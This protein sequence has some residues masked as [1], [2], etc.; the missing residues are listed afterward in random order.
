MTVIER[1]ESLLNERG[2]KKK[3]VY[4]ILGVSPSTYTTWV[5]TNTASIP[6]EYVPKIANLFGLTC[7]ELLTGETKIISDENTSRLIEI[8][9]SLSWD[10][11]Q[12]VIA[13][14]VEEKRYESENLPPR[15]RA[16]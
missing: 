9:N 3:A 2:M 4:E 6:S 5:A 12:M 7:D 13:K 1:I 10:G 11:Q 8:Y 14:A 16:R 15:A